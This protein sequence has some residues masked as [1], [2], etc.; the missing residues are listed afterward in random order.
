MCS[1]LVNQLLCVDDPVTPQKRSSKSKRDADRAL[2]VQRALDAR[3][4]RVN[5]R[6]AEVD[7]REAALLPREARVQ[8]KDAVRW[9]RTRCHAKNCA[10]WGGLGWAGAGWGGLGR[11]GAGW[12][13]LGR[14]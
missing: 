8:E 7:A 10:G 13:G 14:W 9:A 11:A 5:A 3:E 6:T 2:E 1:V 4:A 12:G